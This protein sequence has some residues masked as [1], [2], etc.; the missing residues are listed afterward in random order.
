MY[1][2]TFL[3]WSSAGGT[4]YKNTVILGRDGAIARKRAVVATHLGEHVDAADP[5]QYAYLGDKAPQPKPY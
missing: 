1:V 4:V 5:T 3:T 2:V